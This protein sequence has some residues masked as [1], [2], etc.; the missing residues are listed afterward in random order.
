M[1]HPPFARFLFPLCL[2]LV[3]FLLVT[4]FGVCYVKSKSRHP[5]SLTRLCSSDCILLSFFGPIKPL[6][7][8]PHLHLSPSL[9]LMSLSEWITAPSAASPL[10]KHD[11][12]SVISDVRRTQREKRCEPEMFRCPEKQTDASDRQTDQFSVSEMSHFQPLSNLF[13]FFLFFF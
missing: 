2:L 13:F 7:F 5:S 10:C 9:F 12:L 3:Q 1:S 6:L 11:A 4:E 8:H